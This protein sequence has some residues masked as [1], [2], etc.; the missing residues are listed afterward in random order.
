MPG[1]AERGGTRPEEHRVNAEPD[2]VDEAFRQKRLCQF[3]ATP[4]GRCS[5]PRAA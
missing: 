3:T 5:C 4:S 2:F 1:I